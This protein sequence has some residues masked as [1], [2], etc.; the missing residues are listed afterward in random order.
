MEAGKERGASGGRPRMI[1]APA[2]AVIL[3]TAALC[4]FTG[5]IRPLGELLDFDLSL[6]DGCVLE[7]NFDPDD[8]YQMRPEEA[9]AVMDRVAALPARYVGP[10]AGAPEQ[11]GAGST[12]SCPPGITAW[13]FSSF[14]RMGPSRPGRSASPATPSARRTTRPC[15]SW[16]SR[17]RPRTPSDIGNGPAVFRRAV[18]MRT[19]LGQFPAIPYGFFPEGVV[20]CSK[21]ARGA[22]GERK[23]ADTYGG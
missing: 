15:G 20:Q 17:G 5:R 2:A 21:G 18:F 14:M 13:F 4:V 10:D 19:Y 11:E 23:E 16:W 8:S 7:R 6:T 9:A 3:I 1:C 22:A 12:C